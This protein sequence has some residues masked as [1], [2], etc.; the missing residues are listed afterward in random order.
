MRLRS[1]ETFGRRGFQNPEFSAFRVF[2]FQSLE[3]TNSDIEQFLDYPL[4]YSENVSLIQ[5]KTVT[6]EE[7]RP[8]GRL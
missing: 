3:R 6:S 8:P 4:D 1:D 7:I 5:L 2:E